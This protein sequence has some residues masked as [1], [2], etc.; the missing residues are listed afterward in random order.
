MTRPDPT[1]QDDAVRALEELGSIS[2]REHTM[3]SV[4]QAVAD[5]CTSVMPGDAEASITIQD[6]R[7]RFTVVSTGR[8]ARDLDEVQYSDHQGPCLHAAATGELTEITDTR[9]ETRWPEYARRAAGAG[10]LSSLSVPLHIDD[11]V[12][13]ALNIYA[14]E[15]DA[16]TEQARAAAVRF[17]PY[18]AVAVGN[19]HD[20]Q[21]AQSTAQNLQVALESRAVI[22]QTKGILMERHRLTADQA[23]QRLADTSSR[24]NVKL[25]EVA[26]HLVRTGEL[27]VPRPR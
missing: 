26:D 1:P 27:P 11:G 21:T 12:S 2:L 22:D 7:R 18:A 9:T 25:R 16:F 3:E 10:N 23:F 4:L 5:L 6:R 19:M 24:M 14:R 8:L 20:F 17:G 13:G 15:A